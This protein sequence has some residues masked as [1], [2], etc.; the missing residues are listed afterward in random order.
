M[1][2][3]LKIGSAKSAIFHSKPPLQTFEQMALEA[4]EVE[5]QAIDAKNEVLQYL[6]VNEWGKT[7]KDVPFFDIL[8]EPQ[9]TELSLL[10]VSENFVRFQWRLPFNEKSTTKGTFTDINDENG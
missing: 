7:L 5:L 8:F 6:A 10:I 3:F 1:E 2:E 4:Y 9:K